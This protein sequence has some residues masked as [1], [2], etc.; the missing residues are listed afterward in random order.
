M[1]NL[2]DIK[3]NVRWL[4]YLAETQELT[5]EQE[6]ELEQLEVD[7]EDKLEEYVKIIKN[8]ESDAETFNNV[9][10]EFQ[11]KKHRAQKNADYLRRQII[12]NM[13]DHDERKKRVG[14]FTVGLARKPGKIV[15]TDEEVLP[16]K[17][18]KLK[19]EVSKQ[20]IKDHLKDGGSLPDGVE[21]E[22]GT[23]VTI[24]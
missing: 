16:A 17:F 5:E 2:F 21:I 23:R 11:K 1:A 4:Q 8:L 24:R 13:I 14:H 18:K 6:Q 12:N 22:H 7:R 20:A 15:V 19:Q 10:K 9:M 3:E